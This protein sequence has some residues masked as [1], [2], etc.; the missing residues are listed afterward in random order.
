MRI[1]SYIL[2]FTSLTVKDLSTTTSMQSSAT[3]MCALTSGPAALTL[4]RWMDLRQDCMFE[5]KECQPVPP[6]T[7][8]QQTVY[9]RHDPLCTMETEMR[10]LWDLGDLLP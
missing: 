2:V 7:S 1:L 3:T 9:M 10:V 5:P 6:L 8:C 4:G